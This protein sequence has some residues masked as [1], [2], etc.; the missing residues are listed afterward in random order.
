MDDARRDTNEPSEEQL[1]ARLRDVRE[2]PR[3]WVDAAKELPAMR[4][5][6]DGIVARAEADA[7]YREQVLGDLEE[8]LRAEGREPSPNLVAALRA[9]LE[10]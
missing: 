3:A 5:E 1:A 7:A 4:A 10:D 6:L 9:R 2:P 8:A